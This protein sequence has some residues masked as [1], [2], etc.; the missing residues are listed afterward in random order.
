MAYVFTYCQFNNFVG[1][2]IHSDVAVRRYN[3]SKRLVLSSLT[4]CIFLKFFWSNFS[5]NADIRWIH[6]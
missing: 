6:C 1:N 2:S 4:K 3:I 5:A